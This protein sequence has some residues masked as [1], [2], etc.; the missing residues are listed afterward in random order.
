MEDY[1]DIPVSY[2]KRCLSLRIM[3]FD[4]GDYCDECG[5]TDIGTTDISSWEKMYEE[6][7]GKPFRD[8]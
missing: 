8:K 4:G 5:C 6:K 2:C 7:Y 3:A 1:N